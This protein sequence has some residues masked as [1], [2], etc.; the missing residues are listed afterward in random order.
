[1]STV[2]P[3]FKTRRYSLKVTSRSVTCRSAYAMLRKS[4]EAS[5]KGEELGDT[6]HQ[7]VDA[8]APR[9]REH[10]RVAIE[11]GH[12]AGGADEGAGGARHE[13]GAGGDV[14]QDHP[15]RQAGLPQRVAPVVGPDPSETR[16]LRPS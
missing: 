4:K 15:R 13:A 14:E 9:L 12:A 16:P 5:A 11:P 3:G 6:L 7:R 2:P 1:M 8:G 10:A